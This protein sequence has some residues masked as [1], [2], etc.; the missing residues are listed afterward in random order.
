MPLDMKYFVLKPKGGGCLCAGQPACYEGILRPDLF[1]R[2]TTGR[3]SMVLG[4]EGGSKCRGAEK[5]LT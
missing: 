2:P 5:E 1:N 3:T 4:S